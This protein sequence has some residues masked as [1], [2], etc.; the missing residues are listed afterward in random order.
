MDCL[1]A[2]S[3]RLK[4]PLLQASRSRGAAQQS[5][6]ESGECGGGVP[7]QVILYICPSIY[8]LLP[9]YTSTGWSPGWRMTTGTSSPGWWSWRGWWRPT[10]RRWRPPPASGRSPV[11]RARTRDGRTR[12]YNVVVSI[13]SQICWQVEIHEYFKF[14]CIMF[15]VSCLTLLISKI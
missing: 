12:G 6:A 11:T 10:E 3:G 8:T 14:K 2:S 9:I 5:V 7:N 15:M 13:S 1:A 4:S